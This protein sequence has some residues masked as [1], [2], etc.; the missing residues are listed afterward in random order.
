MFELNPIHLDFPW[1]SMLSAAFTAFSILC[2][3]LL[4]AHWLQ[5]A[6]NPGI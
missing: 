3:C 1:Y 6:T 2:S 4:H 5:K